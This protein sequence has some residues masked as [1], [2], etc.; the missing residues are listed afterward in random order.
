MKWPTPDEMSIRSPLPEGYRYAT[1]E[2][3]EVPALIEFLQRWFP[4]IAVGA[5]SCY[6]RESFYDRRVHFETASGERNRDIFIVL[7]K[8]GTELA[9]IFSAQRD[10]D[11]LSLYGRL[12]AVAEP[13][14][15][16]RLA[17]SVLA[18]TEVLGR[19][20][21]M[22]MAFGMATLHM[23]YMQRALENLGF[24]LVGI[25]PGYDREMVRPGVVKRVYEALYVKVLV[26]EDDL[27]RP[28][29]GNLTPRTR[30][31]FEA[32]F[33]QRSA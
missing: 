18:L 4:G 2:R 29:P 32:L 14:R 16:M 3:G 8:K 23:P 11:T 24:Q 22:G 15:N 28:D 12:G 10:R 5:G 19:T 7:I 17:E 13:H 27:L 20:M 6:L 33:G 9:A 30:A 31:L 1:L 25:T 21:G 26:D